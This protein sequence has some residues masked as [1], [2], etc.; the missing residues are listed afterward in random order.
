METVDWGFDA[1]SVE[2]QIGNH[3]KLHNAIAEYRWE[4]DKI[5]AD[6]VNIYFYSI[7]KQL[8]KSFFFKVSRA[9]IKCLSL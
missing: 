7:L 2:Q 8:L 3:R 5:K 4:L 1:A 6:L 9:T